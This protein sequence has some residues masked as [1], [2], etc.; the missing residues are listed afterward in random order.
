MLNDTSRN[1]NL[2]AGVVGVHLAV[3]L[4]LGL[5]AVPMPGDNG[6]VRTAS[7]ALVEDLATPAARQPGDTAQQPAT[8]PVAPPAAAAQAVPVP[9]PT[10][11]AR[12]RVTAPPTTKA[13][14]AKVAPAP[15]PAA[16]APVPA[17]AAA[18]ARVARRTPSAIE[19]QTAINELKRQVGGLMLL[20]S[21]TPDQIAQ[22]GDQVCTAFDGGQSFLQVKATG[23]S[24]IPPSVIVPPTT[25]DWAVR[26]AVA[27]YCPGHAS[28]LV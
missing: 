21:P 22:A 7:V 3:A 13:P 28:K 19:V 9:V 15:A 24:M 14:V 12:P 2:L 11:V 16:V 25:A 17:V 10:T 26:Q 18:P 1:R 5:G 8:A 27:L 4:A 23:L 20:V 6:P